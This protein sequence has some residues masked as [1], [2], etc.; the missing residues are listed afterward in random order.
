[1]KKLFN[2][3]CCNVDNAKMKRFV[4]GFAGNAVMDVFRENSEAV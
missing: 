3:A 2:S 4:P 1:M